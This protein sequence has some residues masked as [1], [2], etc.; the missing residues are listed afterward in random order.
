M[1]ILVRV[2]DYLIK[3]FTETLIEEYF[4]RLKNYKETITQDRIYLDFKI[5]I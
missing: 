3:I 1:M 5:F 4:F 2:N